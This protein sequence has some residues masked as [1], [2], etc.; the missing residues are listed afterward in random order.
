MRHPADRRYVLISLSPKGREAYDQAE[1][2][3]LDL[4]ARIVAHLPP[5]ARDSVTRCMD[6][7]STAIELCCPGLCPSPDDAKETER[8]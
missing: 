7:L 6:V 5:D 8:T 2:S 3:G 1:T 4:A